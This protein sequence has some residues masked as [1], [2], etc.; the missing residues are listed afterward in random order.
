MMQPFKCLLFGA[1]TLFILMTGCHS[2]PD[3]QKE[4]NPAPTTDPNA[5]FALLPSDSTHITFTNQLT[6]GLNTNVL[7]YEYFYNGGGVAIG[8]MNGDGWEDLYFSGNMTDNKLYLNKGNWQFED[9]TAATGVAGRPGPW[10]TGVC[11]ADVNGDGRPDIFLCYSGKVPGV[12]RVKQ[13][14]INEGNDAAGVPHFSEQ[15]AKYG[16]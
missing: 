7:L 10:K 11:I 9:V 14:F 16:L 6:E 12:K 4:E 13:L 3:P 1:G 8:D 5:L 15:A 2:G